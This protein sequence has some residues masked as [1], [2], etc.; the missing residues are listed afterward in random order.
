MCTSAWIYAWMHGCMHGMDASMHRCMDINESI[1]GWS[2]GHKIETS[3]LY[4]C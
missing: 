1:D 3:P 2:P 4:S